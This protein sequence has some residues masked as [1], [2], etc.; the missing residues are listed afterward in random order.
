MSQIYL[1]DSTEAAPDHGSV[2]LWESFPT[3]T[4]KYTISLSELVEQNSSS[5]RAQILQYVADVGRYRIGDRTVESQLRLASGFSYWRM[6]HFH[7]Q[8]YSSRARLHQLARLLAF[9]DQIQTQDV[10]CIIVK[11]GD[12]RLWRI[13]RDMAEEFT[14]PCR[15]VRPAMSQRGSGLGRSRRRLLKDLTPPSFLA[16][17]AVLEHLVVLMF[18]QGR[19]QSLVAQRI[20]RSKLTVVD[21]WY[22]LNAGPED[23]FSSQYWTN[24]V[25]EIRN[26]EIAATWCHH[27]VSSKNPL[28]LQKVARRINAINKRSPGELHLIVDS[29]GGLSALISGV[30]MY[31]RLRVVG[32][33]VHPIPAAFKLRGSSVSFWGLFSADWSHSVRGYEAMAN[34]LRFASLKKLAAD[35][36]Q[37]KLGMYLLERQPWE[38][39]WLHVWRKSNHGNIV[40]VAHSTI[41][42]WD[43]RFFAD[44]TEYLR[45]HGSLPRP[46]F[47]AINGPLARETLRDA[48][49]PESEIVE[50]EALMYLLKDSKSK[51]GEILKD[52]SAP[53]SS[54][55]ELLR[56]LVATDFMP[57]ITAR[58]IAMIRDALSESKY[59][60]RLII[61]PHWRQELP[62]LPESAIIA[63]GRT[64]LASLLLEADVLVTSTIS[65]AALDAV[66]IGIPVVQC[67]DPGSF[68]LSPLRQSSNIH[69]VRTSIELNDVLSHIA[70]SGITMR[71][72]VRNE[73]LLHQDP[74]LPRWKSLIERS[75]PQ[76]KD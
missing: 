44:P 16:A 20:S 24:L 3:T 41:R 21:F 36:P 28:S 60:Y 39:A 72:S 2:Y 57:D 61:K 26:R 55:K 56:I 18:V 5:I 9:R 37:Q 67:L 19:I 66:L 4:S 34:C 27:L 42:W 70:S 31:F 14:I 68:N 65:S 15:R 76:T 47:L 11:T 40:G 48:G 32:Q 58:Q 51:S 71:D 33:L 8:H 59:S 7:W 75:F 63:D 53:L 50:V 6:M 35:L 38:M 30:L 45:T 49:F 13:V 17:F 43:L 62:A 22:R 64:A 1:W 69:H 12:R 73:M 54:D 23:S 29:Y 46:D 52:S 74:T 25:T 10:S